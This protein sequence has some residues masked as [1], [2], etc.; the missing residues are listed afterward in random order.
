MGILKE[1]NFIVS[2]GGMSFPFRSAFNDL[3][4][5]VT[6][7]IK[8]T[9]I[10][11]VSKSNFDIS[12]FK[13][14]LIYLAKS[15]NRKAS[16]NEAIEEHKDFVWPQEDIEDDYIELTRSGSLEDMAFNRMKVKLQNSFNS[17]R[18]LE[19]LSDDV[20]ANK[21]LQIAS[22]MRIDVPHGF[23]NNSMPAQFRALQIQLMNTYCLLYSKSRRKG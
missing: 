3:D 5:V 16:I 11:E 19:N 21:L 22:G 13:N 23:E 1:S 2:V 7:A 9:K 8:F 6:N 15:F 14:H 10:L 17:T 4:Q 12:K 18:I 20:D